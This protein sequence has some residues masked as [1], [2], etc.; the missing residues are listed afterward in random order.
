MSRFLLLAVLLGLAQGQTL[1]VRDTP[2]LADLLDSAQAQIVLQTPAVRDAALAEALGRAIRERGVRVWIL[3]E[4]ARVRRGGVLVSDSY[5]PWLWLHGLGGKYPNVA[6][7]L[8]AAALEPVLII[9][10][11]DVVAGNLLWQRPDPLS[12]KPTTLQRDRTLAARLTER[13]RR[14]WARAES[15]TLER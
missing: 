5:V 2:S 11:R 9:D 10:G 3:A 1:L 6:V 12:A 15:F 13:F 14:L 8:S 7:R 4:A